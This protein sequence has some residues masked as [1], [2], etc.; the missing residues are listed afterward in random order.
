MAIAK[1]IVDP[2]RVKI[3]DSM[4]KKSCVAPNIRQIKRETGLHRATIKT[5][6]DF[7][8]KENFIL[9]YRPLLDPLKAGLN[10]SAWSFLQVDLTSDKQRVSDFINI[11][12]KDNSILHCSEV[13]TDSNRNIAI[14]YLSTSIE[15]LHKKLKNYYA[16]FPNVYSFIK[17]KDAYYLTG[18]IFKHVNEI[19]SIIAILKE[20][21]NIE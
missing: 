1:K 10:L 6:I 5:S 11:V 19:D 20:N 4:T 21:T 18:D 2:I 13:I 12:K 7:M 15:E 9:G 14:N 16:T 3:L 8:E 17:K